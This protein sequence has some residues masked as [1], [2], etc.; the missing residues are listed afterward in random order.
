MNQYCDSVYVCSSCVTVTHRNCNDLECVDT[1]VCDEEKLKG[2]YSDRM[3][4]LNSKIDK[5][6][7]RKI[8]HANSI[9][10]KTLEEEKAAKTFISGVKNVVCALE[11]LPQITTIN[12]IREEAAELTKCLE[13][14][15]QSR[16]KIEND[17]TLIETVLKHGNKTQILMLDDEIRQVEEALNDNSQSYEI[18][19]KNF[20]DEDH[21]RC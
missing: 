5:I 7:A 10:S 8:A 12:F 6:S 19:E 2:K 18:S 16:K 15:K 20:S 11:Q 1:M 17:E 4:Q 13:A 9:E 14:C 21:F 3:T